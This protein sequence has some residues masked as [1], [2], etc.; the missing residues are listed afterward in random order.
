MEDYKQLQ[1]ENDKLKEKIASSAVSDVTNDAFVVNGI[2]ILCKE[3]ESI[4]MNGMRNLSDQVKDKLGDCIVIFAS[5][6]EGKVNL[7]AT[8][9]DQAMKKGAH[10]GKLIKEIAGFVGG[11]GGGRPGMAQAGGKN[12]SGIKEA[13]KKAIQVAESQ[14]LNG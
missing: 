10:A 12:P 2:H 1:K 5:Q 6:A 11:G 13:L 9:S 14:L 8:A 4:D 7:I 3:L